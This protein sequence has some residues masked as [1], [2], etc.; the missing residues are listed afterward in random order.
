MREVRFLNPTTAVLRA[1][2][3]LLLGD[4]ENQDV[5]ANSVQSVIAE[6]SGNGWSIA[7]FQTTPAKFK[8]E[9]REQLSKELREVLEK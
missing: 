6:E 8:G 2:T 1:V 5:S 4:T 7:L 9:L 3:G